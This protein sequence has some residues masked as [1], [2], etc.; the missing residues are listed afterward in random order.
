MEA[1]TVLELSAVQFVRFHAKHVASFMGK[2]LDPLREKAVQT[3]HKRILESAAREEILEMYLQRRILVTDIAETAGI[4][5]VESQYIKEPDLESGSEGSETEAAQQPR[6]RNLEEVKTFILTSFA[7]T[8]LR[9]NFRHFVLQ[10]Q[11]KTQKLHPSHESQEGPPLPGSGQDTFIPLEETDTDALDSQEDE[12]DI[13]TGKGDRNLRLLPQ[14]VLFV[15]RGGKMLA[16][17]LELKEKPLKQGFRRLRWTCVSLTSPFVSPMGKSWCIKHQHI[18]E[19][20]AMTSH[21]LPEH[22]SSMPQWLRPERISLTASD[23]FLP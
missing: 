22:D 17:F 15:V 4:L 6:F 9:E 18:L 12:G 3:L 21:S 20:Q 7:M 10:G 11:S 1:N 14:F 13:G 23:C 16:E 2:Q 5:E 19:C 8:T